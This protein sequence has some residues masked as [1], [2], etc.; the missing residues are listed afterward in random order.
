M[1]YQGA[2]EMMRS[3]RSIR[4]FIDRKPSRRDI[5]RLTEAAR[6]APSNHNRQGWKFIVFEDRRELQR[7]AER[8]TASLSNRIART[9]RMRVPPAQADEIVRS[10]TLFAD[11][12]AAILVMHKRPVAVGRE[13]LAGATHGELVS[14]EP[15]SAAMA[16]QNMLL[17]AHCLALAACVLTAPL[18]AGEVW[19]GLDG[20]PVGFEPTCIV[21]VGYSDQRPSP[22]RRKSLEQILE[23]R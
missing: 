1:D 13:L 2:L 10:A 17:A 9:K 6:W 15:L 8:I 7:L 16:V 4:H 21:A 19:Q 20:L 11:A 14:G 22:P 3:R 12:P 18:L 5:Q 23:Y